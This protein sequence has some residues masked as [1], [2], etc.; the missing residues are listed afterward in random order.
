MLH[1]CPCSSTDAQKTGVAQEAAKVTT[2]KLRQMTSQ[3]AQLILGVD[4]NAPWGDV[5]KVRGDGCCSVFG[6]H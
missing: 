6:V 2:S 4:K 1:C 3:E 5:V